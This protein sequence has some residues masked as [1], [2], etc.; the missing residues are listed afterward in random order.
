VI[1]IGRL[2]SLK[3]AMTCRPSCHRAVGFQTY[4]AR[5][6]VTI[7]TDLAYSLAHAKKP[8]ERNV[9]STK[10][11]EKYTKPFFLG[12]R[13]AYGSGGC[14]FVTGEQCGGTGLSRD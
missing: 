11:R 14:E 4:L 7:C 3:L 10:R 1:D 5:S 2:L 12:L 9:E 13:K 6:F 8:L